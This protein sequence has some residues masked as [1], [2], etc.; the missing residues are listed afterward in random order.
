MSWEYKLSHPVH[1]SLFDHRFVDRGFSIQIGEQ[2]PHRMKR[3]IYFTGNSALIIPESDGT[4][5]YLEANIW[6]EPRPFLLAITDILKLTVY[7]EDDPEF[8][9]FANEAEMVAAMNGKSNHQII[10]LEEGIE[11]LVRQGRYDPSAPLLDIPVLQFIANK[12][13]RQ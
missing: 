11:I 10:T 8:W 2:T 9:G 4:V 3:Q 13:N 12:M 7:S 5:I 6:V 1:A